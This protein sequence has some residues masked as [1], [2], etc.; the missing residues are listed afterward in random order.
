MITKQMRE[1]SSVEL[2]NKLREHRDEL[3]GLHLKQSSGQVENP[4]RFRELRREIARMK[5]LQR[6]QATAAAK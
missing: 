3:V 4:A 6:Q 1:L 5:T 2:A